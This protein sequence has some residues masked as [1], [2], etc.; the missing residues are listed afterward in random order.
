MT[1]IDKRRGMG[2]GSDAAQQAAQ[3]GF[4]ANVPDHVKTGV[5]ITGV[6]IAPNQ[7]ARVSHKLGRIPAGWHLMR[8]YAASVG[9]AGGTE[10]Y[11]K[12]SDANT[13]TFIR[14][15]GVA[16]FTYDFWVF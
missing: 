4:D 2:A 10:V 16:N 14:P 7:T 13:I 8:V 5:K 6:T 9:G 11:E 12:S 15:A 3:R 1:I